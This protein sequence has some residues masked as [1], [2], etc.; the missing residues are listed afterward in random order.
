MK[1][2][3]LSWRTESC[4]ISH[5]IIYFVVFRSPFAYLPPLIVT[6]VLNVEG[7]ILI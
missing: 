4:R 6:H 1:C 2:L 3:V 5:K 7:D